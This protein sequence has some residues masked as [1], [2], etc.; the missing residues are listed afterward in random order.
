[1]KS[2]GLIVLL[3][4]ALLGSGPAAETPDTRQVPEQ[5]LTLIKEVQGQQ[6]MIADNQAKIDAKLATIAEA[7]RVAR[8]YSSRGG[9]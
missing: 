5:I 9:R 7:M 6:A 8:I 2:L 1:M 3:S 4:L